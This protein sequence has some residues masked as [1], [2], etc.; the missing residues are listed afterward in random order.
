MD[1]NHNLIETTEWRELDP[2]EI[3]DLCG[4]LHDAALRVMNEERGSVA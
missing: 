4:P 1:E 3:D 2:A